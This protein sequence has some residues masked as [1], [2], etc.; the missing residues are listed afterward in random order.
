MSCGT[1]RRDRGA[2]CLIAVPELPEV[3]TTRRGIEPYL[4]GRRIRGAIVR[5]RRLRRPV[6]AGLDRKVAG[7]TIERL[8]RRGK[9]LLIHT[10]GGALIVHLGMSGSLRVVAAAAPAAAHDHFDLVL[11]PEEGSERALRFRDPRRFGV[12]LW[13][14]RDPLRHALLAPLGPEPLGAALDGAYLYRKS[15][16]RTAPVKQFIMDSKIVVGVGN[17]YASEALFA[18]G[19]HPARRAGRVSAAR[20]AALT[21]AIRNVLESAI[22]KGGTTLRDFVREDGQPGY[23]RTSLQVYGRDG[24]P[25]PKCA[26]NIMCRTIGQRSSFYCAVCQK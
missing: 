9:Y 21:A 17:I 25:C 16:G 13:T 8:S 12:V 24:L 15:R 1:V 3:E 14:A 6:T 10:D 19:I 26:G 2:D 4:V 18:A 11:A 20:Y 5:Q 22:K 7:R 23:F